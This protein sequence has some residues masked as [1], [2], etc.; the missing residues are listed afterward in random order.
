MNKAEQPHSLRNHATNIQHSTLSMLQTLVSNLIR[1]IIILSLS[2]CMV[3]STSH[4]PRRMPLEAAG[5][6]RCHEINY[7]F[8]VNKLIREII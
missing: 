1:R 6:A 5:I 3:F 4:F 7:F 8:K 2:H